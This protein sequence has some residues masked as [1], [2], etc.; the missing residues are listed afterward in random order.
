VAAGALTALAALL[1][2]TVL[3]V[4]MD[5]RSR[6]A[7]LAKQREELLKSLAPPKPTG[8]EEGEE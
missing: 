6:N 4:A 2:S 1:S 7:A 5:R 3:A 8:D